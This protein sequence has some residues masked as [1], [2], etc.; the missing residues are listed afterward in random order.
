MS[1]APLDAHI[2][3]YASQ[4]STRKHNDDLK[5]KNVIMFA[6]H[7]L[8]RILS[9]ALPAKIV[10]MYA[11]YTLARVLSDDCPPSQQSLGTLYPESG[12]IT[13]RGPQTKKAPNCCSEP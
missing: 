10:I 4:R 8:G 9:D 3:M 12:S 5:T 11:A 7:S 13:A 1:S 6:W 2:I